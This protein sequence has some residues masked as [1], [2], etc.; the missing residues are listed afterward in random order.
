MNSVEMNELQT[1]LVQQRSEILN[2]TYE[3]RNIAGEFKEDGADEVEVASLDASQELSLH[4]HERD[5]AM[6][7]KID[8]ALSK[9]ANRTFGFCASCSQPIGTRRL[10]ARPFAD[11]CVECKEE[12]ELGHKVC[13][14]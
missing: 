12:Q 9:I 6:L 11:L 10:K 13:T 4:L 14:S 5:R 2:K 1:F 3:F 7:M 8:Q